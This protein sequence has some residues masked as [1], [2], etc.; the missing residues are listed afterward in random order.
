MLP[1][2]MEADMEERLREVAAE[3]HKPV[4]ECLRDAVTQYL[5]DRMDYLIAS[6]AFARNEPTMTLDDLEKRLG[7]VR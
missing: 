4:A 6:R 1:V 5:D 3:L 7:M 2:I